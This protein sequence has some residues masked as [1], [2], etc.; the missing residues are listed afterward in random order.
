MLA[1]ASLKGFDGHPKLVL[2]EMFCGVAAIAQKSAKLQLPA[3]GFDVLKNPVLERHPDT[4]RVHL[5]YS[6]GD[7][8]GPTYWHPLACNCMQQL[9]LDVS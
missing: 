3:M 5:C 8:V 7:V 6:Y 9:G 2:F 4:L 1:R